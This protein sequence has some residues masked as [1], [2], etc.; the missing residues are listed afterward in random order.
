MVET[1]EKQKET[2]AETISE[3]KKPRPP[4][5]GCADIKKAPTRLV[6]AFL[7]LPVSVG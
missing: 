2:I 4:T 7:C 1:T 5:C 3:S 6:G